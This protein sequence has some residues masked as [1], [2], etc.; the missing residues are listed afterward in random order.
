M[1]KFCWLALLVGVV[2]AGCKAE[3]LGVFVPRGGGDALQPWTVKRDL[4]RMTDPRIGGRAPGSS[5]SRR[6]AQYIAD[7]FE[8]NGLK[9][10]FDGSFRQDLGNNVGE[11]ICGVRQGSGEQA[12]V[13]VAMDPGIGILSAIPV[14]GIIS[15]TAT[16]DAPEAPMHSIYFCVLPAAGGLTGFATKGPVA[17]QRVLESFTIGTLT[18]SRI[19]TESGPTLGPVR[20]VL[21][22]S[23]PLPTKMS[24]DIGQ[25]DY[26]LVIG[27]LADVYSRVS[28]V[29]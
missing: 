17:Y 22:H 23:G 1:L 6:V 27:R 5:G 7:R 8:S 21:L 14:A 15:L 9:P 4:W 18:G 16:F 19:M 11:M 26:G 13:V 28:A 24:E 20:T 2:V 12:V 10:V 3:K 29:D 25:L